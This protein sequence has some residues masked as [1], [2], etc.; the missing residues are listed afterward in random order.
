LLKAQTYSQSRLSELSDRDRRVTD[1][2]EAIQGFGARLGLTP[3]SHDNVSAAINAYR[4]FIEGMRLKA[5]K[6]QT[7][8]LAALSACSALMKLRSEVAASRLIEKTAEEAFDIADKAFKQAEDLRADARSIADAANTVRTAI[9]VRV[10][11]EALNTLWRD[12]FVRLAPTE[13]FVPAFHLPETTQGVV[14]KLET[15]TRKGETGG[16]PG[17]MLSAGNLNTAALTLFLALHLSVENK[18]PW[19]ILDDP[20]QS[21]DEV[22]IAQFAALLRT[23]SKTHNRKIVIAVHERALFEYLRLELSPAF[24]EDRLITVELRRS[25]SEET[26]ADSDILPYEGADVVAA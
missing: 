22:H 15:R 5:T 2:R 14:A 25:A 16:A 11:N 4:E 21:M 8:R 23:L 9:V 6:E 17:T 13:P 20:V 26:I 24:A 10:F 12:L 18:L 19:L 7:A 1:L 3:Q